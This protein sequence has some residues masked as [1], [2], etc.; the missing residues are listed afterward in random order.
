MRSII[1]AVVFAA[2]NGAVIIMACQP[3]PALTP[4]TAPPCGYH[5]VSC[6]NG[7]CCDENEVCG[8]PSFTGCPINYCCYVGY[9]GSLATHPTKPQ[10]EADAGNE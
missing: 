10:R 1:K 6:G 7:K 5:G 8:G 2:V 9:S 3:M 4:Y